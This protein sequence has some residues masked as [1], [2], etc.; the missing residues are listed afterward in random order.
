MKRVTEERK[1]GQIIKVLSVAPA[2][3]DHASLSRILATASS[4]M[5]PDARWTLET[6]STLRAAV[7]ALTAAKPALVV[8]EAEIGNATWRDLREQM[9]F[10][11]DPPFLIVTSRLADEYLWAEALNLGAYDVLG[12][13]YEPNE[14]VRSLSQAWINRTHGHSRKR[15]LSATGHP[16]S[17]PRVAV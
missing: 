16:Q 11:P 14:V 10:L 3:A 5:C 2:E 17:E 6:A 4:P 8:C 15:A 9:A 1:F 12:K 7:D 13:P